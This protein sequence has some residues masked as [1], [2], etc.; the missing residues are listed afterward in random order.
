MWSVVSLCCVT[1]AFFQ[2]VTV[3]TVVVVCHHDVG[4]ERCIS[5]LCNTHSHLGCYGWNGC[6][7]CLSPGCR[8]GALYHFVLLHS[9]SF[10][11]LRLLLLL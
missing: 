3:G 1:F 9:Q 6:C 11:V 10:R 7:C 4:V 2:G 8:C 5:L